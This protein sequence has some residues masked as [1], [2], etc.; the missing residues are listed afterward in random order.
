M[1]NKKIVVV[2]SSNTDMII[3]LEHIPRPGETVLGGEFS[4]APGGKGANQ[5]VSSAR[6]GGNVIFIA[7]VGDDIFGEKAVKGFIQDGINVEYVVRDKNAPSGVALI[8]VDRKGENSIAV[9]SGANANLSPNDIKN[10]KEVLS[11]SS[12]MLIQLEIPIETVKTAVKIAYE[13]GVR[14]IL[15]PAPA[16]HLDDDL[17]K[18]I[19]IITPNETEVEIL[20]GVKIESEKSIEKAG[21]I[22]L[23][24]GIK[25]VLITIGKRGVYVISD[26]FKCIIPSF[27][28]KPVDTT[29]AGD[30]FNGVL[31]VAL[32]ENMSL[33]DAVRFSNAA[34]ALSVTKLGA[35][36][37]APFREEIELFLKEREDKLIM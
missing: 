35:Q 34:A 2:G 33:K 31:A 4:V 21:N 19:D 12:I 8:F 20:T 27:D 18:K 11:K 32:S 17:L 25:T 5:A 22:L 36:T 10:A 13:N 9:A 37:S 30:V 1:V 14:V 7:R 26:D 23:E 24:K 15:N 3:K 29:A 28:V 16:Q 6:A